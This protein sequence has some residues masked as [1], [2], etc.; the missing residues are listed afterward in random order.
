MVRNKTIFIKTIKRFFPIGH[1]RDQLAMP[2]IQCQ[3]QYVTLRRLSKELGPDRTFEG[4]ESFII[5]L[6]FLFIA[7]HLERQA[8]QAVKGTLKLFNVTRAL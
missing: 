4:G 5:D 6:Q 8:T 7:R 1:G 2:S 3:Q